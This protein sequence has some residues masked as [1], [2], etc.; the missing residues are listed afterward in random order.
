MHRPLF[1]FVFATRKLF[2]FEENI[3]NDLFCVLQ[4]LRDPAPFYHSALEIDDEFVYEQISLQ[5]ALDGKGT[6]NYYI[7]YIQ[8][9]ITNLETTLLLKSHKL[10]LLILLFLS[11]QLKDP[12]VFMPMGYLMCFTSVMREL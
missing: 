1:E 6:S 12:S 9:R 10:F 7:L 5:D 8:N 2:F 3:E 4:A 11:V